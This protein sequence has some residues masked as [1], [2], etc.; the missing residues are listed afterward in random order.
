MGAVSHTPPWSILPGKAKE[1]VRRQEWDNMRTLKVRLSGARPFPVKL[2]LKPPGGASALADMTGF[3]CFIEEWKKFPDQDL[4]R[5]T[6]RVYR[7][8]AEQRIPTFVV[9][10][11]LADIIRFLGKD[12]LARSK[13]WER[14]MVPLLQLDQNFYPALVSRLEAVEKLSRVDAEQL[15][16]LIPQLQ[17]GMGKGRFQ[18]GLPLVGID[19]KFMENHFPLVETLVD[20]RF[21]GEVVETGGLT[22]WLQ[23]RP[24]P[25]DWLIIRP[26]CPATTNQMGNIPIMKMDS[27]TL[28][29]YELPGKNI[30]VVE[31]LQSGLALP[32]KADTVAVIGGGKNIAWMDADWVRN[33]QLFYWGD[34]DTW[35]LSILSDVREKGLKV[36]VLMMDV[37]T[38]FLHEQRMVTEPNPLKKCPSSLTTEEIELFRDLHAG[39]F[40]GT[41]LEQERLSADYIREKL[42]RVSSQR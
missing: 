3:R 13:R 16:V 10:S 40:Q 33:K 22:A 18:R 34:I 4:I 5:W 25:K 32:Q 24:T 30:M 19:T 9:L 1:I 2:G 12:A 6:T 36:E 28:S 35:G 27:Y 39:R 11:S 15:A 41:R 20:A 21:N 26:L 31:N 37:E 17:P 14:N 8:L 38:V 23:C 42:T 29:Q 7:N